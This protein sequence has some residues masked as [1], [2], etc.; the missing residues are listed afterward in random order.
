MTTSGGVT[1]TTT[2][3]LFD[4]RAVRAVDRLADDATEVVADQGVTDVRQFLDSVLR[5][6]TGFY[7][8]RIQTEQ[9]TRTRSLVTDSQVVYGPWLAGVSS[10]NRTSRFKGYAHWRRVAQQLQKN[11]VRITRPVVTRR[12]RQMNQ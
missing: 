4:G 2:G 11:V 7:Q 12:V 5:N 8:S 6:P 9:K 3:P 1:V 10:R